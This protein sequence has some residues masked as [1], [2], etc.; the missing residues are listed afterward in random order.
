M[1]DI[2]QKKAKGYKV[3][4]TVKEYAFDDEG[5]KKLCK[6]KVST[7]NVPP[8]VSAIKTYLE[9]YDSEVYTMTDAQLIAEKERL[10]KTLNKEK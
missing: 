6:E 2:L 10:I 4:E 8:D 3:V 1:L 5:N 7:K 9:M